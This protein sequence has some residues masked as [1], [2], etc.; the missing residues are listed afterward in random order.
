MKLILTVIMFVSMSIFAAVLGLIYHAHKYGVPKEA[1]PFKEMLENYGLNLLG[2]SLSGTMALVTL[3]VVVGTFAHQIEQSKQSVTEMREQ[4]AVAKAVAKANYKFSLFDK[5]L[6]VFEA[7]DGK[8]WLLTYTGDLLDDAYPDLLKAT[9]AAKYLFSDDSAICNWAE[10][11]SVVA[12]QVRAL[13]L[14]IA[15][16]DKKQEEG[17]FGEADQQLRQDLKDKV[18]AV[19][20]ELFEVYDWE[21]SQEMFLPYLKLEADLK[22]IGDNATDRKSTS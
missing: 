1:T 10:Q 5:R 7:L 3:L 8:L 15:H 2:D 19:K 18:V 9:S 21:K 20:D 14:R 4:N 11:V 6:S 16:L 12:R 13:E 17:T 22:F